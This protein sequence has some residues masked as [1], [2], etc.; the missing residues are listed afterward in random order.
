MVKGIITTVLTALLFSVNAFAMDVYID[1]SKLVRDVLILDERA[2]VQV[3]PFVLACGIS[4]TYNEGY[5]RFEFT[6]YRQQQ[7]EIAPDEMSTNTI[8]DFYA[9]VKN[10]I[11]N[12]DSYRIICNS[13][14]EKL[15][16]NYLSNEAQKIVQR[17]R[18]TLKSGTLRNNDIVQQVGELRSIIGGGAELYKPELDYNNDFHLY[19]D[20]KYEYAHCKYINEKA[21]VRFVDI[22]RIMG[23]TY[24][25]D[26]DTHS[27]LVS[28]SAAYPIEVKNPVLPEIEKEINRLLTALST[29]NEP[30]II[31]NEATQLFHAHDLIGFDDYI[32]IRDKL[33]SL[34][35]R[36]DEIEKEVLRLSI[37]NVLT[38]K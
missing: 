16:S 29:A 24:L 18:I 34:W 2:Y 30:R 3:G 6:T 13:Y 28:T 12:T 26:E 36:S 23:V 14:L 17:L 15:E 33:V 5:N 38:L 31:L 7:L 19:A 8:D 4:G 9:Y 1:N 21:Y 11:V 27:I 35:R 10:G 37:M 25:Y 22:A 20:G 32:V